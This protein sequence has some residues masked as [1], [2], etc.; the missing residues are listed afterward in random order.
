MD[1]TKIRQRLAAH[2]YIAAIWHIEDVQS[3]RSD[4]TDEQCMEVL[5]ECER[6]HDAGIGINWDV[7]CYHADNLFPQLEEV[8]V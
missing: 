8:G 2:G 5:L 7:L 1:T 4:L 3:E 6:R